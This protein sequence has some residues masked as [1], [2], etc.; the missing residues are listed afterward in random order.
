MT[1]LVKQP[2]EQKVVLAKAVLN[3]ADQLGLKQSQLAAIL[4]VHR[5]AI[6]RL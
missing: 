6:S 5:T 2:V 1:A 3:A 4:G